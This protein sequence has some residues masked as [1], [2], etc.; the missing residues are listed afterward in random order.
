[1]LATLQLIQR[2]EKTSRQVL[3]VF[4]PNPLLVMMTLRSLREITFNLENPQR[5]RTVKLRN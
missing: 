5:L 1:M 2:Q 3:E 4:L